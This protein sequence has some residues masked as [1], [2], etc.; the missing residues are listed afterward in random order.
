MPS[1]A[2]VRSIA[3]V[4]ASTVRVDELNDPPLVNRA[5]SVGSSVAA[6]LIQLGVG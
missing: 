6:E 5:S 2:V 3:P 1:V 4:A